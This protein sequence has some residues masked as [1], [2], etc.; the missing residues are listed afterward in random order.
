MRGDKNSSSQPESER[1]RKGSVC[2]M[3]GWD[4]G[5]NN[6]HY[7]SDQCVA[8]KDWHIVFALRSTGLLIFLLVQIVCVLL[9]VAYPLSSKVNLTC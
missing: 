6:D 5:C 9:F 4:N 1:D 7:G 2:G 8:F 3:L